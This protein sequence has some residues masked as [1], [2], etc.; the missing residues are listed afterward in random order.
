MSAAGSTITDT[1]LVGDSF[2]DLRTARAASVRLCLV[3]YGFGF[4]GAERELLET[5]LVAATP[6]DVPKLIGIDV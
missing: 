5:D 3:R 6:S 1:V 2:I 4:A